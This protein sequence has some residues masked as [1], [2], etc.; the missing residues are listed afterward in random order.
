M[1]SPFTNLRSFVL[2]LNN[3]E[4]FA[5][6][7]IQILA[8]ITLINKY[9][10]DISTIKTGLIDSINSFLNDSNNTQE[11]LNSLIL[12]CEHTIQGIQYLS[13]AAN[14]SIDGLNLTPIEDFYKEANISEEE[15]A[16]LSGNDL[17]RKQM[18]YELQKFNK[19]QENYQQVIAR[20]TELKHK[21]FTANKL[22]A[23]IITKLKE[24]NEVV[25][26]FQKRHPELFPL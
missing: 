2:G 12:Q 7:Y 25:V 21:L 5:N 6:N 19:L 24:L 11:K 15:K 17:M 8:K 3:Q 18:E 9:F 26:N 4:D 1:E 20:S 16:M 22:Y 10:I 13:S 14:V 23:P